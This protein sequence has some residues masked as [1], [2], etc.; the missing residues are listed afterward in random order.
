[1]KV[2][3]LNSPNQGPR[4]A[5]AVVDCIV[6]HCDASAHEAATVSWIMA[7]A[8]KVSYHAL[9]SRDGG[10]LWA[11]VP[12]TRRAWHAGVSRFMN[13]DNCNDYS[14]GVSLGNRNDGERYPV[15]QLQAAAAYCAGLMQKHP[16]I[17]LERITSHRTV[18]LPAGR[19]TDP[20]PPFDLT[21]FRLMVAHE[22]GAPRRLIGTP[23]AGAP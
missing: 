5:G 7:P 14:V 6:M 23:C 13:R 15:A 18:A 19:K 1:M 17:T 16:D 8:S 11:F 4:P 20:T 3:A 2:V 10:T 22:L 12:S 21:A 9:V